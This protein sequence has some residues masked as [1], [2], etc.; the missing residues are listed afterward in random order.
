MLAAAMPLSGLE[1][2]RAAMETDPALQERLNRPH[3]PASFI[4]L[5]LASARDRGIALEA[6]QVAAPLR[7]GR[8]VPS[9]DSGAR[10]P[11]CGWLPVR[12]RW[13]GR[14]LYVDWAYVG[15][16]PLREP[17]FEQSVINCLNTPF[18]LLFRYTTPIEALADAPRQ[19]PH[20]LP[21]GFIFHM[22]RCGS[23][24][25]SRMLAASPQHIVVSEAD[26][27][28]VV[29][30]ARRIRPDLTEDEQAA[31]LRAMVGAFGQVRSGKERH[32]FVKLDSWHA[33][34]LPLFR[35]AFPTTPWIFV[36][37]EPVEILVSQLRKRGMHMIPE[38]LGNI[39]DHDRSDAA[40]S[41]EIYCA[42]VLRQIG[43]SVLQSYAQG[44]SHL[45]NYAQLPAAV[46]TDVL[47]HF[48]VSCSAAD[49]AAMADVAQF[50][51]KRPELRFANDAAT[52]RQA[53]TPAVLRAAKQLDGLHARLEALR[54]GLTAFSPGRVMGEGHD[55]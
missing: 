21:T 28:D 55:H 37:W 32:L 4:A 44:F 29:V 6:E 13:H 38:L 23:T 39:F 9:A 45:V 34:A 30:Q 1:Q 27:I 40:Q 24:L 33:L 53:A 15:P 51:A 47:P 26:P 46:W 35:R 36:Y 10:L 20:V 7:R 16:N 8:E 41:P 22:S 49:R 54:L 19:R 50:N 11:P 31:A 2:F 14:E 12:T 3:D 17:F 18:N 42:H 5:V 52:K 25:V 43:E 48:G